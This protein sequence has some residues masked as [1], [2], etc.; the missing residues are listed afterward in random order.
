[1]GFVLYYQYTHSRIEDKRNRI[2]QYANRYIFIFSLVIIILNVLCSVIQQYD[3]SHLSIQIDSLIQS[4][5]RLASKLDD[6]KS[7]Q[8]EQ[9]ITL[10]SINNNL[11]NGNSPLQKATSDNNI[12]V[13]NAKTS[14]ENATFAKDNDDFDNARHIYDLNPTDKRIIQIYNK[15]ITIHPMWWDVYYNRGLA[16]LAVGNARAA[17][18]DFQQISKTCT[19]TKLLALAYRNMG[20]VDVQYFNDLS[21]AIEAT[22]KAIENDPLFSAAYYNLGLLYSYQNKHDLA[23]EAYMKAIELKP[24]DALAYNNLGNEYLKQSKN[25]QGIYALK[26][27]ANLGDNKAQNTIK[28]LGIE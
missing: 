2:K 15:I 24:D 28:R 20:V 23:I 9:G 25:A 5:F 13:T 1:M 12:N 6:L 21:S 17:Y 11:R 27:A 22:K 18:K 16:Y 3:S 8:E 19:D 10:T 14:L 26:K 4:N 7:T